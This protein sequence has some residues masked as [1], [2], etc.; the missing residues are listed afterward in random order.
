MF[1][2]IFLSFS[3]RRNNFN[4]DVYISSRAIWES[5]LEIVQEHNIEADLGV[6]TYWLGMNAY[7]DMVNSSSFFLSQT[8]VSFL[9]IEQ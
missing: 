7:A 6:H 3:M 1:G 9:F 2:M 5:N 4:D 8:N